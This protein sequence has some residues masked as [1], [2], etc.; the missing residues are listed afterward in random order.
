VMATPPALRNS[1]SVEYLSIVQ[2]VS[3]L[4]ESQRLPH[5]INDF[6][7]KRFRLF[8]V[9]AFYRGQHG[10]A[11]VLG[12]SMLDSGEAKRVFIFVVHVVR[13]PASV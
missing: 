13:P 5:F 3:T 6:C 4:R 11:C 8:Y 1:W 10:T 7:E 2:G 12:T 9:C